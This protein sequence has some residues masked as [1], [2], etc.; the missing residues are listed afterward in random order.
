MSFEQATSTPEPVDV[1]DD[2]PQLTDLQLTNPMRGVLA[3]CKVPPNAKV[4]IQTAVQFGRA[5]GVTVHVEM[6]K[7]KPAT[8][9]KR[10]SKTAAKAAAA[11]AKAEAQ[12]VAK[13]RTCADHAVRALTWPPSR[14]RDAFTTTF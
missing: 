3:R 12:A 9:S 1:N 7:R 13:L 5:I 14:R 4:T 8:K 10:V 2:R 11:A 6:P